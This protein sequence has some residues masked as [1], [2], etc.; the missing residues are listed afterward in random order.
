MW[1][2]IHTPTLEAED[3][4]AALSDIREIGG[5]VPGADILAFMLG[6]LLPADVL[7]RVRQGTAVAADAAVVEDLL[8]KMGA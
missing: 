2:L 6:P 3:G 4:W 7:D 8:K 5:T 1:D